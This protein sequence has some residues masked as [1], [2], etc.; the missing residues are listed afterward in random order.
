MLL[1]SQFDR[2]VCDFEIVRVVACQRLVSLIARVEVP[3]HLISNRVKHR[4]HSTRRNDDSLLAKPELPHERIIADVQRVERFKRVAVYRNAE[5]AVIV[6]V[7]RHRRP[8]I[9]KQRFADRNNCLLVQIR[10]YL[11]QRPAHA[12]YILTVAVLALLHFRPEQLV[13]N[14]VRQ[15]VPL[16]PLKARVIVS[17]LR[18][19]RNENALGN[20]RIIPR[21]RHKLVS[22]TVTQ[23][24]APRIRNFFPF[25][26]SPDLVPH[27]NRRAAKRERLFRQLLHFLIKGVFTQH[28]LYELAQRIRIFFRTLPPVHRDVNLALL[29]PDKRGKLSRD[30]FRRV[31]PVHLPRRLW[32]RN[33]RRVYNVPRA[34]KSFI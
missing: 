8:E 26:V 23:P 32:V 21:C 18:L 22:H 28:R 1:N 5:R 7:I 34:I 31:E 13:F 17:V 2:I 10:V 27:L 20:F 6:Y 15:T 33:R 4:P 19:A 3:P 12:Q 16:V 14:R 9:R 25:A 29:T 24:Y 11:S 30:R